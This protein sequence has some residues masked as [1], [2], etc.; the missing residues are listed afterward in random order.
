MVWRHERDAKRVVP[1]GG[2]ID[3]PGGFEYDVKAEP[4]DV[5]VPAF[6]ALVGHNY[7]VKVLD[8]HVT[9][10]LILLYF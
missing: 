3:K 9:F 5:K 7:R 1:T 4:A 2:Q 6:D 10:P 8:V